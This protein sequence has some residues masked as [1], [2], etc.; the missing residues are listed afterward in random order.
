MEQGEQQEMNYTTS[1][2]YEKLWKLALEEYVPCLYWD[3]GEQRA[4]FTRK[5]GRAAFTPG[6]WYCATREKFIQHCEEERVEALLPNDWIKIESDKDL[7]PIGEVVLFKLAGNK[8][9]FSGY[10]TETIWMCIC[11]R[12]H[13]LPEHTT[14]W[15][16]MP[17][18]P[19]E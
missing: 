5:G 4:G 7:P 2:D 1:K 16:P 15:M 9:T 12:N 14:H 10:W 17:E 13:W 8:Y 18:A 19:K 11:S 6:G 3:E